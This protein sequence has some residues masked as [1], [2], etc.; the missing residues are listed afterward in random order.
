M[1][2]LLLIL[3]LALVPFQALAVTPATSHIL[4][5]QSTFYDPA[6]TGQ[7]CGSPT[8]G[9]APAGSGNPSGTQVQHAQSIIGIAKTL[10]MGKQGALIGLMVALAESSLQNYANDGSFQPSYAPLK[11]ISE[12]LP[13]DA[14]GRD[15]DSVGLFQQR[16]V[17]GSWGPVS[18][19]KD[20]AGNVKWLMTPTYSAEAFFAMPAG[21]GDTKALT[22]VSGWQT[23]DPAVAA[24]KVQASGDPSGG[25]YRRQ[26]SAAEALLTK[27]YDSSPAIALPVPLAKGG[28]GG[29]GGNGGSSGGTANSSCPD[30]SAPTTGGPISGCTNPITDHRWQPARTDQGVDYVEN[31]NIPVRAICDGTI[32]ET[33]GGGWPGGYFVII[34]M[35]AGPYIG[36]C[37]FVAEHLSNVLP[38]G[39]KVKAGQQI[40]TTLPGYPWTEWGW[41]AGPQT[42]STTYNGAADGSSMPGGK[43]F[44]RFLRHLGAKTQQD[45]GPGPEYAGSNCN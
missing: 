36:K 40:A 24:Q 32:V 13:H 18:P 25:N 7:T 11:A 31:A 44:A 12:A 34:K 26:Q 1:R 21:K 20:L 27:Y 17:D 41:A 8:S 28:G 35:S 43:A 45:P 10:N 30:T 6:D 3:S 19:S 29:G 42:P 39:T 9:G 14:V 22:N 5:Y 23:M 33:D 37:T 4:N 16:A 38:K 2:R 15:H